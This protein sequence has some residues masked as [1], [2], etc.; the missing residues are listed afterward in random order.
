MKLNI[1]DLFK[2]PSNLE[3][4]SLKE[5]G[6]Y[7]PKVWVKRDDLIHDVI[8][9]NKWRKLK[10]NL[11]DFIRSNKKGILTFGGAHSNHIDAVAF[12]AEALKIPII[13]II[14][15]EKPNELSPTLKRC[16]KMGVELHFFQRK[17]YKD[18]SKNQSWIKDRFPDYYIIPEG[19]ANANGI[20]GC[21]E[22]VAEINVDFDEIYCDV[23]TGA[24]CAGISKAL[25]KHQGVNGI[26]VLKG[27]EY[28]KKE[29]YQF[30]K[31]NKASASKN[32]VQLFHDYH[33]GGYGKKNKELISFMRKFYEITG[34]KTDPIYSGKM[35]YG[36]VKELQKGNSDKE[37]KIIALHSGG[38]QGVEGYENRYGLKI[39]E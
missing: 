5:F 16:M 31:I 22:I 21:K 7:S 8:S 36:L 17:E 25:K 3:P 35:F 30:L 10:Y 26:V 6:I 23:G 38:L 20:K 29:I 2:I 14:R 1:A 19:G 28:L 15:G 13:I 33:M 11:Q 4:V 34:I 39:Y 32:K 18:R 27:A 12:I 24:T 37:K 9:G